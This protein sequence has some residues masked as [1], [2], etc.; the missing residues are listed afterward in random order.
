[1]NELSKRTLSQAEKI[2]K[3]IYI[4][5]EYI[6]GYILY[7]ISLVTS[8]LVGEKIAV[9]IVLLSIFFDLILGIWTSIKQD[10]FTRSQLIQDTFIKLTVY[11]IPLLLIGLSGKM[12]SEWGIAFYVGCALAIGC[13][14]WSISAHLLIIAPK[15]P[16]VKILRFQLKDEI[17]SKT[18][19][20]IEELNKIE[21]NNEKN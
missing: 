14:L 17:K 8:F 9:T 7:C 2:L 21:D 5:F 6:Y 19:K 20:D 3:H 15:M 12:F 11:G 18:G 10:K 13:E 16:F 4:L 1:M